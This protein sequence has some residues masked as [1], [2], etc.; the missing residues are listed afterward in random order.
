MRLIVVPDVS[1]KSL[2]Q[3]YIFSINNNHNNFAIASL[4]QD[5][6]AHSH[7]HILSPIIGLLAHA[8]QNDWSQYPGESE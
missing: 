3:S 5:S 4:P 6:H 1:L 7:H 8:V 2:L